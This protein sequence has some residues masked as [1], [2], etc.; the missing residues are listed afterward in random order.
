MDEV[1]KIESTKSSKNKKRIMRNLIASLVV[2]L[3]VSLSVSE[4]SAQESGAS[5]RIGLGIHTPSSV[6]GIGL[7]LDYDRTKSLNKYISYGF[8]AS[9]SALRVDNGVTE[10]HND[11]FYSSINAVGRV[12]I[13]LE[14]RKFRPTFTLTTGPAYVISNA[15]A[16]NSDFPGQKEG[17]FNFR[18]NMSFGHDGAKHGFAVYSSGFTLDNLGE[19]GLKYN[20]RF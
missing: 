15:E 16:V 17:G 5:T 20:I 10:G 9:L 7:R 18:S 6:E 19:I 8:G 2:V 13:P 4:L 11:Y 12:H 1:V 14:N 3:F